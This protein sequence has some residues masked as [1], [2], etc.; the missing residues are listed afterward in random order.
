MAI[1]PYPRDLEETGFLPDGT[2]VTVRPIRAEDAE[3]EQEFVRRLS[4]EA[5]HYRFMQS[6][7]ELTPEMLV[8]FTQIDYAREM[9]LVAIME[10]NAVKTQLGVARYNI[11]PDGKSCEF[12]IVVSDEK[13]RQGIGSRLMT[14]LMSAARRHGLEV[15]EG[16]VLADNKPMLDLMRELSFGVKTD[17]DDRSVVVV[18]RRL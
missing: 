16:Y 7:R 5:K 1:A 9:A 6:V 17:P 4:P 8:R 10:E 14:A 15:M 12:A 2:P 18:E 11:N 13:Q 3:S